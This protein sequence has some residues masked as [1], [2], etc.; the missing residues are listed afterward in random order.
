MSLAP[1]WPEIH[2]V[3]EGRYPSPIK[4]AIHRVAAE[5]V[6]KCKQGE[7]IYVIGSIKVS[8]RD[9]IVLIQ[10]DWLIW[11]DRF[12]AILTEL[13]VYPSGFA[14]Y[15]NTTPESNACF[16]EYLWGTSW[17]HLHTPEPQR[18]PCLCFPAR[19]PRRPASSISSITQWPRDQTRPDQPWCVRDCDNPESPILMFK[20]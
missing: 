18:T 12:S 17:E 20:L 10:F 2:E 11:I 4:N 14:T 1:L 3:F 7:S 13:W 16:P 15:A 9:R 8:F 6:A 5:R 19:R